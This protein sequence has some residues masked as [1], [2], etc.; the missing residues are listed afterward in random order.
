MVKFCIQG[1]CDPGSEGEHRLK[2]DGDWLYDGFRDYKQDTCHSVSFSKVVE[3]WKSLTVG[4]EEHDSTSQNDSYFATM[5]QKEW[6]NPTCEKYTLV[7][8]KPHQYAGAYSIC[9]NLGN[10]NLFEHEP[11]VTVNEYP[12]ESFTWVL[13]I[14]PDDSD[15]PLVYESCKKKKKVSMYKFCIE[16]DCDI[17][18]EGRLNL[19]CFQLFIF[20][21]LFDFSNEVFNLTINK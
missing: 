8:S 7:L 14:E 1:Y 5:L 20:Q 13:E 9:V 2:L 19:V 16:G 11:C 12:E 17:G 15:P 6:Y 18:A 10:P 4:T 21:I 3:G